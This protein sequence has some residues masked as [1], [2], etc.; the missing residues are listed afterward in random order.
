ME[1]SFY[2]KLHATGKARLE[3]DRH[4]GREEQRTTHIHFPILQTPMKRQKLGLS[5]LQLGNQEQDHA[6]FGIESLKNHSGGT[7]L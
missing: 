5:S 6:D 2:R 1:S 7:V 4:S 3:T